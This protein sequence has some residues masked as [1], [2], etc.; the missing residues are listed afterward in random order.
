MTRVTFGNSRT[1]SKILSTN[2]WLFHFDLTNWLSHQLG[3]DFL[4]MS[5]ILY[6]ILSFTFNGGGHLHILWKVFWSF[7]NEVIY[8]TKNIDESIEEN[9]IIFPFFWPPRYASIIWT[10]PRGASNDKKNYIFTEKY[11]MDQKKCFCL[12]SSRVMESYQM[13]QLTLYIL[14]I[15]WNKP[16]D[17]LL[18]F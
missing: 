10:S 2:F 14:V 1:G 15:L 7:F 11:Y 4:K 5:K 6:G 18:V 16:I 13:T 12:Q 9:I 3:L 17:K 8:D